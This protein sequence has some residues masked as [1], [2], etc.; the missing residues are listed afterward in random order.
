M[1]ELALSKS[2]L[3]IVEEEAAVHHFTRVKSIRLEIGALSCVEPEA[4][5]FSFDAV[6]RGTVADGA[7]L[8]I[9]VQPGEAWCW[10]CTQL[11]TIARRG[12][13]CPR[14]GG[15]RLDVRGGDAMRVKELEVE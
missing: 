15:Y 11:A 6:K 3:R 9:L 10:D 7:A 12:E 1:H 14:C 5:N 13:P 8:E 4:L 2:V